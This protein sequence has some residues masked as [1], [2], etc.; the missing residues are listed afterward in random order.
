MVKVAL[1]CP[2]GMVTCFVVVLMSPSSVLPCS[3][4]T[5]TVMSRSA[6]RVIVICLT[7]SRKLSAISCPG[8]GV[9]AEKVGLP[10]K[11]AQVIM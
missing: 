3:M 1:F 5:S 9:K 10:P 6:L 2:F 7:N 11:F 4:V 8:H